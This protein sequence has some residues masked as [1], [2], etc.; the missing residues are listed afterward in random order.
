MIQINSKTALA[1]VLSAAAIIILGIGASI[2]VS[3]K[4]V[5]GKKV[6]A[7]ETV[8]TVDV[9]ADNIKIIDGHLAALLRAWA[10]TDACFE[11]KNQKYLIKVSDHTPEENVTDQGWYML[12]SYSFLPFANG[13]YT[14]VSSTQSGRIVPDITGLQCKSQPAD[15][16]WYK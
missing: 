8:A 4:P 16:E 9:E 10:I 12:E 2:V 15:P 6:D 13:T 7:A 1:A 5:L 14:L 3:D 11:P